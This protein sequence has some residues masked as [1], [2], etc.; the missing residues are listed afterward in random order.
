MS[1]NGFAIA[2]LLTVAF[3]SVPAFAQPTSF[4]GKTAEQWQAQL[5][6]DDRQD[7]HA[8]AWALA[9]LGDVAMA[10][11]ML[12]R[13]TDPVVSYWAVQGFGKAS[14][15]Q[16]NSRER[17]DLIGRIHHL[18]LSQQPAVRIAAAEQL[19][20]IGS[21]PDVSAELSQVCL[22]AALPVLIKALDEPQDSAAAQ[23]AAALVGLGKKAAPA[24]SKLQQAR[25]TGSEYVKRHA[26]AALK[27]LEE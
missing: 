3:L 9:Q 4:L 1:N 14:Q 27:N 18:T 5:Q 6:S 2:V 15:G 23:A 17:R 8:A 7:R 26:I 24:R 11:A 10:Q 22:N 19:A 20:A 25:E 12:E 21:H 16:L 13:N